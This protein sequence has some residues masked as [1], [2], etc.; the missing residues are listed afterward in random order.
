MLEYFYSCLIFDRRGNALELDLATGLDSTEQPNTRYQPA[1]WSNQ[2]R[3]RVFDQSLSCRACYFPAER[4]HHSQEFG[5]LLQNILQFF[6]VETVTSQAAANAI[7][8][9]VRT[10]ERFNG[11]DL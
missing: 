3:L 1:S 9:L 4:V 6:K 5:V 11:A 10:G 7:A 8:I 2:H